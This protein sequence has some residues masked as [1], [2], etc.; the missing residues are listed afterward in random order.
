MQYQPFTSETVA[1]GHPDKIFD[2]ISD[3]VAAGL[4]EPCEVQ[5][6]YVIGHPTPIARAVETFGTARASAEKIEQFTWALLDL[7][8]KGIIN[9]LKLRQPIYR[10]TAAY[11]HF[12][13][14]DFPW[15]KVVVNG[16]A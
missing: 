2:Q 3:V 13:R 16:R 12:G 6:A 8:V 14:P 7:S 10:R 15:E 9:G 11:G 4:A 1:A 5:L